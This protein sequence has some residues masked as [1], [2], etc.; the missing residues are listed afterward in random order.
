MRLIIDDQQWESRAELDLFGAS[1]I[2]LTGPKAEARMRAMAA[3]GISNLKLSWVDGEWPAGQPIDPRQVRDFNWRDARWA[4]DLP[5]TPEDKYRVCGIDGLGKR[6]NWRENELVL[7]AGPYASGKSLLAQILAQDF[8]NRND[9]WASLTCWEDQADEVRDG[10]VRYC[11]ST[12]VAANRKGDFLRRFRITIA[13]DELDRE[14]G[15]HLK[16]IEW[17]ATRFGVRF[18]VLDPWNEF[19]H[20]KHPKQTEGDYVIRVLTDAAKLCNRLNIIIVMTTHVAAEFISLGDDFKPFRLS[21]AFGSSQ[22]GNKV[23]R[24]F[25]VSR[26]KAWNP[27]SHMIIR[28]DKVKLENKYVTREGKPFLLKERMGF[29]DTMAFL[30]DPDVN[31]LHHD[32]AYSAKARE[33]WK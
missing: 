6:V 9:Q 25:C 32:E 29:T 11:R 5:E 21:N 10:L 22:F 16:R 19:D 13:H 8:V 4:D 2:I 24:G 20:K 23:H 31:T 1:E 18:F 30:F 12:S 14:I 28:Q 17:E 33:K 3:S 15:A 26:T 27:A 7:I